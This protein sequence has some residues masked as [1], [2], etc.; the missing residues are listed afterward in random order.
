MHAARREMKI[1]FQSLERYIE[2]KLI[3]RALSYLPN[4][5]LNT[6]M[7]QNLTM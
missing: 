3:Y 2:V 5:N 7:Q 4:K 6:A 1:L